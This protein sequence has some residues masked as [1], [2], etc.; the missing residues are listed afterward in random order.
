MVFVFIRR[1]VHQAVHSVNDE[2]FRD[3][4]SQQW[5]SCGRVSS[6]DQIASQSDWN[7]CSARHDLEKVTVDG[8]AS[9]MGVM[10]NDL[11]LVQ[12]LE[13]LKSDKRLQHDSETAPSALAQ[14]TT[15]SWFSKFQNNYHLHIPS[16][17]T[18]VSLDESGR[19]TRRAL[20]Q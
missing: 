5:S 8:R 7:A 10:T 13:Q 11:R 19:P 15:E 3:R 16:M 6:C 18:K 12:F 2:V 17:V 20:P 14:A 9:C 4:Y 1:V